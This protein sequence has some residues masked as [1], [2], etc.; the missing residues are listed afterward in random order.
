VLGYAVGLRWRGM[1]V[2]LEGVEAVGQPVEC[3]G[4]A[5]DGLL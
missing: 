4:Q 3:F 1:P 5:V 2:G